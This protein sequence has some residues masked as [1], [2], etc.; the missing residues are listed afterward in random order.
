M[1]NSFGIHSLGISLPEKRITLEEL[2]E[3]YSVDLVAAKTKLN[4]ETK[5]IATRS[6]EH[7]SDF[8]HQA[9]VAALKK[10]DLNK[11]DIGLVIYTGVSKDYVPSWS[12]A[13]EI[14]RRLNLKN[15]IGFDLTLGC[16]SSL[17]ALKQKSPISKSPYIL[18]C[19]AERWSQ[20]LSE[21][22]NFSLG[23]LAH[24]DG[25]SACILGPAAQNRFGSLQGKTYPNLN[26]YIY[27]PAGGTKEPFSE[28]SLKNNRH[29][30]Q[31]GTD[32]INIVDHY[33]SAYDSIINSCLKTNTLKL[34]DPSYFII[35]QV[36]DSM[37]SQ[38]FAKIGV[39]T[40]KS[41]YTYK[42]LGHLGS[43][44][45]FISLD[46]IWSE[47]KLGESILASSSTP[48]AYAALPIYF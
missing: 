40:K 39:D 47:L 8:C 9:S 36:R 38:I 46:N 34:S 1:E 31:R 10:I 23:S 20:T 11:D 25:G 17:L 30:R 14:I 29:F 2:C 15:A 48:S 6:D 26:S 37:R 18:I 16:V 41:P 42:Q 21:K 19:A 28:E 45:L 27:T 12:M 7:P 5:C 43:A 44:D 33:I 24:A 13:I 32:E 22:V 3:K 4:F 35:N